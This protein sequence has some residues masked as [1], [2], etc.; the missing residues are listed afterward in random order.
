M[1]RYVRCVYVVPVLCVCSA[2]SDG[3]FSWTY[4]QTMLLPRLAAR[5]FVAHLLLTL[6]PL[7]VE[8]FGSRGGRIAGLWVVL[9]IVFYG[10]FRSDMYHISCDSLKTGPGAGTCTEP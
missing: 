5:D 1:S 8:V 6:G 3:G 2:A 7:L 9:S 10:A 4:A